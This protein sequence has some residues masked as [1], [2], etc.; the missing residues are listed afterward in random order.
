M[1]KLIIWVLLS[2][3]IIFI[4][5]GIAIGIGI[6]LDLK[7]TEEFALVSE[8]IIFE[9]VVEEPV[10]DVIDDYNENEYYEI[11]CE[12]YA[13]DI[14]KLAH[15]INAECGGWDWCTDEMCY[16]TGSVVL[17]R[18]YS[19]WFPD[20]IE[21]VIFQ[22]GQ[23]SPVCS[24]SYYNE[25]N[26]RSIRIAKD[27]VCYGSLLPPNVVFQANFKQGDGVYAQVQNMYFCYKD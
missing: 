19:E 20:T 21:E 24:G 11:M 8:P 23:Y 25:P 13:D 27:L 15:I 2:M 5:A 4:T 22:E 14:D 12:K 17:N 1:R 18:V 3:S 26:E 16:Y 6:I 7:N 9:D 10:E